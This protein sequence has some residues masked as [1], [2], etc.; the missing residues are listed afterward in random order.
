MTMKIKTLNSSDPVLAWLDDGGLVNDGMT[1]SGWVDIVCPWAD[2][3]SP[4]SDQRATYSPLGAGE[5]T[6]RRGFRCFHKHCL[7][8]STDDF[9]KWVAAQGGPRVAE[10]SHRE[11]RDLGEKLRKH[12]LDSDTRCLF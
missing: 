10:V 3:H 5:L 4:G 2:A 6:D 11:F 12:G 7:G 1:P 9:L 8:R